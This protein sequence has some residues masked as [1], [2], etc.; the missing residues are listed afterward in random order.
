MKPAH[1]SLSPFAYQT[2]SSSRSHRGGETQKT[3]IPHES[4]DTLERPPKKDHRTI[5]EG[6]SSGRGPTPHTSSASSLFS[7]QNITLEDIP[8]LYP[9]STPSSPKVSISGPVSISR[10]TRSTAWSPPQSLVKAVAPQAVSQQ[11]T[12]EDDVEGATPT[13]KLVKAAPQRCRPCGS[14]NTTAHT[15]SRPCTIVSPGTSPSQI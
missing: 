13:P 6:T 2:S 11:P 4:R 10:R 14:E 15:S 7:Q 8:A 9:P 5:E 12:V 3:K 1:S